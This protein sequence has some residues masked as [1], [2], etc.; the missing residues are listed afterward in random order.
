MILETVNTVCNL[1][2]MCLSMYMYFQQNI[3]GIIQLNLSYVFFQ[4][5][6]S[7]ML[8]LAKNIGLR[9]CALAAS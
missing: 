3:P 8:K 5:V 2:L 9:L 4:L 1:I 7:L 6:N